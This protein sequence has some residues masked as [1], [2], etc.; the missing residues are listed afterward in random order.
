MKEIKITNRTYYFYDDMINMRNFD[1]SFLKIDKKSYKNTGIYYIEYITK[2]DS[3]K[4]SW[5]KSLVFYC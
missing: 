1:S 4:Y 2:K 5:C 3:K